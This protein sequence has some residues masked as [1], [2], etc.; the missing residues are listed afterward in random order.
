MK[1]FVES[2]FSYCPIT[3]MFPSRRLSNK[4][5]NV[6]KKHLE[7]FILIINQH[8]IQELLDKDASFAGH[9]RNI[10]TLATEIYKHIHGLSPGIME[11]FLRSI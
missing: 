2:Q 1:K 5:N 7:L 9:H 3:W 6:H 11:K 10:Q 8:F 4:I